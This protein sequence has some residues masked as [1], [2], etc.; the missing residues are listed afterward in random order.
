MSI[1]NRNSGDGTRVQV[2]KD[3]SKTS[4][5]CGQMIGSN[6]G[7]YGIL[8]DSGEYIDVTEHQL[9]KFNGER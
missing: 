9:K 5:V 6:D 1:Q 2:W 3:R 8:L 4:Y 7:I